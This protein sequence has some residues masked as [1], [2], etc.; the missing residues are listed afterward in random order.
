MNVVKS[1]HPRLLEE[2][3][4]IVDITFKF[5]NYAQSAQILYFQ[6]RLGRFHS[7]SQK[8]YCVIHLQFLFLDIPRKSVE[9]PKWHGNN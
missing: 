7:L 9:S 5:G 6:H 8:G 1:K 4:Q 3:N 2:M